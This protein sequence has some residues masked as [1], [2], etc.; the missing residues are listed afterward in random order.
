[1]ETSY[2]LIKFIEELNIYKQDYPFCLLHLHYS[3]YPMGPTHSH[4]LRPVC[5]K[6]YKIKNY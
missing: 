5:Y 2:F 1:M 6:L 3:T 4:W